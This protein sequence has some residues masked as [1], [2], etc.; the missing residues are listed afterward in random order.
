MKKILITLF[1]LL[2]LS[3]F[4]LNVEEIT[5]KKG[6]K[7]WFVKDTVS[8]V[9]SMRAVIK[10]AGSIQ[11]EDSKL[12][13]STFAT[14]MMSRTSGDLGLKALE[15]KMEQLS[16]NTIDVST[17]DDTLNITMQTLESS[18]KEAFLLLKNMLMSPKFSNEQIEVLR[19]QL[20]VSVQD[21]E[22]D[23]A[24][25]I[26]WERRSVIYKE[27]P[28]ARR[29]EGT[30]ETLRSIT[31]E[32]LENFAKSRFSKEGL[33]IGICGNL[34]TEE[35][36]ELVDSFFG[37][38]PDKSSLKKIEKTTLQLSG[39]RVHIP[40]DVPQTVVQFV[41]EGFAP[42]ESDF[43][44]NYV[45]YNILG[46]GTYQSLLMQEI[47]VKKGLTY[48]I[49]IRPLWDDYFASLQGKMS[50]TFEKT[51]DAIKSLK[52]IWQKLKDEGPTEDEVAKAKD[53]LINTYALS[54]MT[55]SN[56]SHTLI[57]MQLDGRDKD[58]FKKRNDFFR[59]ITK[60]DVQKAAKKLLNPEKLTIFTIGKK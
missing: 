33:Y 41:G 7:V 27:H 28:Y 46:S 16:I 52:E 18:K 60:D 23:P 3:L 54:F 5:T 35:V 4:G 11:D 43:F 8:S 59:K 25:V 49:R 26:D 22:K 2:P 6:I 53:Y 32:D 36:I 38:F 58:Y 15:R 48:D 45:L 51:E 12:G 57:Q 20:I 37:D 50:T 10:N 44:A 34:T 42:Q 1:L 30:E 56:I 9:I 17:D 39:E 13:L 19:S 21:Q 40:W 47:R 31:K 14:K 55:T 24:S 29:N